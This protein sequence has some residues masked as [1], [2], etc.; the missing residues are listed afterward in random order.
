MTLAEELT[1]KVPK[2]TLKGRIVRN[3][4]W[5]NEALVKDRRLVA[6]PREQRE[7]AMELLKRGYLQ[8]QV[9]AMMQIPRTTI[10]N[11]IR[12]SK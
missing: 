10:R 2:P 9:A 5:C 7:R 4:E 6:R 8:F 12:R 1:R 11:W 3:G